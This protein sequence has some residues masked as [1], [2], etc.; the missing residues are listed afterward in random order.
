ME[1]HW[2]IFWLA[3]VPPITVFLWVMWEARWMLH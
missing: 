2:L 3:W 1:L